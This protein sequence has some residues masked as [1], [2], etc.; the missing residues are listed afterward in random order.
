MKPMEMAEALF[1]EDADGTA[2][3]STEG[4]VD[5]SA[6]AAIAAHLEREQP[7]ATLSSARAAD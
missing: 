2:T 7:A 4:S 5:S 3:A 1:G 6:L